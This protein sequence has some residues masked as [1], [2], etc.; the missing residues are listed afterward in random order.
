MAKTI[1]ADDMFP[2]RRVT[3]AEVRTAFAAA[4]CHSLYV[5]ELA[6]NHDGKRQ[7]YLTS[8]LSAFNYFPNRVEESPPMPGWIEESKK[9]KK[10]GSSRIY[11]HLD[12]RWLD[13][14]GNT[15][16]APSAKLI[17]YPQYPEVRLSGVMLRVSSVP[18]EYMREKAG[19]VF[20]NR[21][22]FLGTRS[23]GVT[24][25]MLMVGQDALRKEVR[26]G[27]GFQSEAGLNQLRFRAAAI[28]PKARLIKKLKEIHGMGWVTGRK[29]VN[30][31]VTAYS[32]QNAVGYTLE[33]LLGVSANGDNEPDFEGYE[34]KGYTVAKLG[35]VYKKPVTVLSIE[36]DLGVY[37][38]AGVVQFLA[39][40]GYPDMQ[41]RDNRQNFGGIHRVGVRHKRTGLTLS[42]VGYSPKLPD[43]LDPEGHLSLFADD[44][45]IAAG[46]SF[47]KLVDAWGRKHARAAYVPALARK[48]TNEYHYGPPVLI[49]AH[50]DLLRVLAGLSQGILYLDP[51]IKAEN[52]DSE[53][54]SLHVRNQF[55]IKFSDVH[56]LYVEYGSED[57]EQT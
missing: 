38:E 55:R 23:D 45:R 31:V 13:L 27:R 14:S 21:L 11:G 1:R 33:A 3:L 32:A 26:R 52:W 25:A 5:K 18:S 9:P 37:R 36:P 24:L 49:C 40:W 16:A 51:G 42:T 4:G 10:P 8:D 39:T 2:A 53:K 15:E 12:Y 43:R 17:Y 54:K 30:G 41:G 50:T 48:T 34:I 29:L 6:W 35:R 44:G 57:L 28:N 47:R 19:E 56:Q 20:K 22:L 46:W 7:I